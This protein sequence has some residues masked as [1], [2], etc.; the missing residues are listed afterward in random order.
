M[1]TL[2]QNENPYV[3]PRTFQPEE[4]AKFFGRSREA[5]ELT[6]LIISNQ[7]VL[8]YSPSGAG[9]SSLLNTMIGPMLTEANFE[10]LPIGRVSGHSG[11]ESLATN[12]YIY[13]LLLSLHKSKSLPADFATLT[14]SQFLDNL[15]LHEDGAYYYDPEFPYPPDAFF[16]P[17]VL[18]ID[19][20]EELVTTNAALWGQRAG[21]FE[22]LAEAMSLDDQLWIV[23][24]LRDDY[25]ARFDP[26]LHLTPNRLRNRYCLERLARP[27]AIE[28][29]QMPVDGLRPFES[30]ALERLADN[31]LRIRQADGQDGQQLAQFIEPVQLQAVCYQ[32][33]EEL[34]KHPG[35]T[36]TVDNVEHFADVDKALINFYEDTVKHIKT[37]VSEVVLR[38]WF[39]NELI[40][41]AGT[42]NMVYRGELKTG[43]LPT[44]VA[45]SILHRFIIREEVR[46]GGV[47]YELVHDRLVQPILTANSNWRLQ[48]PLPRLAQRWL[49]AGRSDEFLIHGHQL[50]RL[51]EETDWQRLGSSVTEFVKVSQNAHQQD[52]KK[53][54]QLAMKHQ[55]DLAKAE[56]QRADEAESAKRKRG[57]LMGVSICVAV[58]AV[59]FAV[60]GV[61]QAQQAS[62]NEAKAIV[63][64]EQANELRIEAEIAKATSEARRIEA[65]IA[66]VAA[67]E[68][69]LE[70]ES[71][72]A[73]AESLR[74]AYP[75]RDFLSQNRNNVQGALL[76][77]VE[78]YKAS[79][80]I[81]LTVSTQVRFGQMWLALNQAAN[82]MPNNQLFRH[83]V[84]TPSGLAITNTL[85]AGPTSETLAVLQGN[86]IIWWEINSASPISHTYSL[87][88]TVSHAIF[89]PD[90]N[91]LVTADKSA[92]YL[93]QK[94]GNVFIEQKKWNPEPNSHITALA[95]SQDGQQIAVAFCP[96]SAPELKDKP[97]QD[98]ESEDNVNQNDRIA[99]PTAIPTGTESCAIYMINRQTPTENPSDP[100]V[101]SNKPIVDIAFIGEGGLI[102]ADANTIYYQSLNESSRPVIMPPPENNHHYQSLAII[103]Y[104][105][106]W[107][108]VGGCLTLENI[109]DDTEGFVRWWDL[110]HGLWLS[111][112][113]PRLK[114][115]QKLL[116][117][118][119]QEMLVSGD[120]HG[121]IQAWQVNMAL[122]PTLACEI[123]GRNMRVGEWGEVFSNRERPTPTCSQFLLDISFATE[124]LLECNGSDSAKKLYDLSEQPMIN[125]KSLTFNEWALPILFNELISS[126]R[127]DADACLAIASKL[128]PSVAEVL[129]AVEDQNL[130]KLQD[131][132]GGAEQEAIY[133][134]E[135][136]I[137][138]TNIVPEIAPLLTTYLAALYG[139]R[140]GFRITLPQDEVAC[141]DYERLVQQHLVS[142]DT[143]IHVAPIHAPRREGW[144]AFIGHQG[145]FL[146]LALNASTSG[147][148][149]FLILRDIEGRSLATSVNN[150]GGE[151]LLQIR[152][153]QNAVYY[154]ETGGYWGNVSPPMPSVTH[155]EPSTLTIGRSVEVTNQQSLWRFSGE[156]GDIVT[157]NISTDD[158]D[159]Y[160]RLI[161]RDENWQILFQ[162]EDY[163]ISL[164]N[165]PIFLP[166]DGTYFIHVNWFD[167][168][169]YSYTLLLAPVEVEELAFDV[170]IEAAADQH[171][172]QFT[173][174]QGSVAVVDITTDDEDRYG[175]LIVRDEN[176]QILFQQD[177]YAISLNNLPI[178]LPN[179]GAYFIHVNWFDDDSDSYTLSLSRV[180]RKI[181][182]FDNHVE[183]DIDERWWQFEGRQ[184]DLLSIDLD[185][186]APDAYPELRLYGVD[187][188]E[189]EH[190][191]NAQAITLQQPLPEDGVYTIQVRWQVD[192]SPYTLSVTRIEP[193]VLL[194]GDIV[195]DASAE[196]GWWQF[197]GRQGDI[198]AI[199]MNAL[200]E[201]D[202]YLILLAPSRTRIAD[203]DDSGGNLNAL[204]QTTLPED[205]TYYLNATWYD[206]QPHPYSLSIITRREPTEP[207]TPAGMAPLR[208]SIGGSRLTSP[209]QR[210]WQFAGLQGQFIAMTIEARNGSAPFLQITDTQGNSIASETDSRSEQ[211]AL[212]Y[213]WLPAHDDYYIT[214]DWGPYGIPGLYRLTLVEM[215]VE[216][217][218]VAAAKLALSLIRQGH[219]SE[220][221]TLL[222]AAHELDANLS[223]SAWEYNQ[224]CWFGSLGGFAAE[225]M[226]ACQM[227]VALAPD[228]PGIADSRGVARAMTGDFVGAIADFRFFVTAGYGRNISWREQWI[229]ELMAGRNPFDDPVL[230]DQLRNE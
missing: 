217:N 57:Q 154:L 219:I 110:R 142:T 195:P 36:I 193:G 168:D 171:W 215:D 136:Q 112:D 5:R 42:R 1:A 118:V 62:V 163:A 94:N 49:D 75:A 189:I 188:R 32:M 97:T 77:S 31:L 93:L 28:A 158:E 22:Q 60:Y 192:P 18:I 211:N 204:I 177:G 2:T 81:S 164:N 180:E 155:G 65:E 102:W 24:A 74:L 73:V 133:N 148:N 43:N 63:N 129:A 213:V 66:K 88:I 119:G 139:E 79:E 101:N 199:A 194:I 83:S 30:E 130:A 92:V 124:A 162:Q 224:I 17:R 13:N 95:L 100:V 128:N 25:V 135:N 210:S 54:E 40:T 222:D 225:V 228:D 45:E 78:I 87:P 19:Q 160:G 107:L 86:H 11:E 170:P 181:L 159:R 190:S 117:M 46:P 191:S 137:K 67:E 152:L 205:G 156:Q 113:T 151:A 230:L 167:D 216:D 104:D 196:Q 7:L 109:C 173:G 27:A 53:A 221:L 4:R 169:S 82:V 212:L 203:N 14:L 202:P 186:L 39:E 114:P 179:D 185:A 115:I 47:W 59:V 140:C 147:S 157:V 200:G 70:A 91:W 103:G 61:F 149:S 16:K 48:Q 98:E 105:K 150:S 35:T 126:D 201:G 21:F 12:I 68:S 223:M 29:M 123:A 226:F 116:Y 166:N 144:W 108:V 20:F 44:P 176:W 41:E 9:K 71:A 206:Q 178:F 218:L 58:L 106:E 38:D 127:Q 76:V 198:V 125:G 141:A 90:P 161:V 80:P 23:L 10:V 111:E 146:T 50:D 34:S 96:D 138:A 37:R 197:E 15:V 84:A 3:G 51:T 184:G 120:D 220:G 132:V 165:L 209:Q 52:K 99:G 122:W 89:T 8:L 183:A 33:W 143:T 207:V 227:A 26:Y 134:L 145:D 131:K 208:I 55:Q 229:V 64:E 175:Q 56:R 172:W 153:P 85:L 6:A 214:V 187:G 174:G 69:E 121:R 72:R 182:A